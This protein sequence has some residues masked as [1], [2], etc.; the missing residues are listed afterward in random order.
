MDELAKSLK[1]A[2]DE[3]L[4]GPDQE[5]RALKFYTTNGSHKLFPTYGDLLTSHNDLADRGKGA[6]GCIHARQAGS[7]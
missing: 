5:L 2:P 4:F 3:E 1:L 7:E 6:G